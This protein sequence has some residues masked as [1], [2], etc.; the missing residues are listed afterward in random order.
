MKSWRDRFFGQLNNASVWQRS[1]R[2]IGLLFSILKLNFLGHVCMN[3]DSLAP[4]H[5]RL[6]NK[7][8]FTSQI[9]PNLWRCS[10]KTPKQWAEKGFCLFPFSFNCIF[11]KMLSRSIWT[12]KGY[13]KVHYVGLRSGDWH[14]HWAIFKFLPFAAFFRPLS[15][16]T[17]KQSDQF[18]WIWVESIA[19]YT[20]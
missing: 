2:Q 11:L 14:Y 5:N 7:K 15:L 16:C 13:W 12:M 19:L 1:S 6:F 10:P 18:S 20:L 17:V 9:E 4:W 3:N 8:L